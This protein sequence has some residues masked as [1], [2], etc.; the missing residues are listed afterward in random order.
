MADEL[1]GDPQTRMF[2]MLARIDEKLSNALK[3]QTAH[4]ADIKELKQGQVDHGNRL[5]A[6]ESKSTVWSTWI[7]TLI[8]AVAA[9]AAVAVV[10]VK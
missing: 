2:E 6:I 9:L 7:P 1:G 10:F 4:E 3:T 5:T 8:A